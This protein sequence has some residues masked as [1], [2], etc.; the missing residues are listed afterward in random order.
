MSVQSMCLA[1]AAVSVVTA[2]AIAWLVAGGG[3]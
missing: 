2:V 3:E 1:Y